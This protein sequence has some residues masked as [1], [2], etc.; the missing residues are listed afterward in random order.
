MSVSAGWLRLL[1]AA[2]LVMPLLTLVLAF[3]PALVF[4]PFLP[5]GHRN[6][7]LDVLDRFVRWVRAVVGRSN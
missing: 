1:V 4:W 5:T 3:I 2:M 6:W 7:L